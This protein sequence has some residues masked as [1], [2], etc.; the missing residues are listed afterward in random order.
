MVR[1]FIMSVLYGCSGIIA[2]LVL[3]LNL[4]DGV[5]EFHLTFLFLVNS[6]FIG[7][8]SAFEVFLSFLDEIKVSF[9]EEVFIVIS[10][11]LSRRLLRWSGFS[12]QA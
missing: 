4:E 10:W 8:L 2:R 7:K 12:C 1:D 11:T 5:D 9:R 3:L 6:L